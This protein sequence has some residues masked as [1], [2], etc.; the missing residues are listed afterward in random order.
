[1]KLNKFTIFGILFIVIAILIFFSDTISNF[2][3]PITEVFLM[4]SSKGKDILFFTILGIFCILSQS[5]F[6]NEKVFKGKNSYYLKLSIVLFFIIAILGIII[7]IA[8]RYYL[9]IGQFTI[10]V[11][12]VPDPTTT[13]IVH[14]HVYK[15]VIG[16]VISSAI[17]N[18]SMGIPI[19]I[20]M[21]DS[22]SPYVPKIANI[23]IIALPILFI[24]QL[25][26][27][28]DRLY[29]TKIILIFASVCG[30]IGII[31][32]GFFSVPAIIGIF[33]MIYIY[34]DEYPI[35]YYLAK[36]WYILKNRSM[37][38]PKEEIDN[39]YLINATK[40]KVFIIHKYS[41]FGYKTFKRFFPYLFVFIIIVLRI[42]ISIIGTIPE[43]YEVDILNP[44]LDIDSKLGK[45][46]ILSDPTD[47]NNADVDVDVDV[48]QDN[49]N[50]NINTGP[51]DKNRIYRI[52]SPEY[53][54]MDLLNN[55]TK[56]LNNSCTSYS[57]SWNIY[58]YIADNNT[59]ITN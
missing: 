32:G 7:E 9:G 42:S 6:L 24:L 51:Y 16:T 38:I 29:P 17:S 2:I 23:I 45:Y 30:L 3:R 12:M 28:K 52:I 26:S 27:L 10:F 36:V 31:D 46:N 13:S 19:G 50:K 5:S 49:N 25:A 11:A 44:S 33:G 58:S 55:L 22:L 34:L 40:E 8:M 14:S 37:N 54:E 20:H 53:N 59:N 21:G 1:M 48:D 57:L 15:S 39:S 4:G 47:N 56:S 43:Y 35:N 18:I 41:L